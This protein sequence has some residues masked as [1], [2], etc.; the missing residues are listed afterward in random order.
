MIRASAVIF[1]RLWI[2][3]V[4]GLE[5][6]PSQGPAI[7]V[8]N[9]RSYYD[10]FMI[11]CL[12]KKYIV[13][14]A[15]NKIKQTSII[16]WFT[17]TNYVIYIE[18]E[19]PGVTFFHSIIRHIKLNRFI[20]IY[21]E[22]TRSRTGKMLKPK[23]GFVRLAIKTNVPIIPVAIKGTYDILPPNKRIPRLRR[24][25]VDIGE[26][27]YV[28]PENHLFKDIYLRKNN[29]GK[30]TSLTGEEIKEM[31]FRIMNRIRI[32]A[33]EEWDDDALAEIGKLDKWNKN[34]DDL[35]SR[36]IKG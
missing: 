30:A 26:K 27:I 13:F 2:R 11:G 9:H 23:D 6:I 1:L 25:T 32:S 4:T 34:T 19:H 20:I 36:K 24:C 21:P 3:K 10:F 22:A 33:G 16:S 14:I 12:L 28:S 15:N 31:A 18:P 29:V 7:F 17:K 35:L 5:N 8:S